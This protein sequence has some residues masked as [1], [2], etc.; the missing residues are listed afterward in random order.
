[1][2]CTKDFSLLIRLLQ[3]TVKDRNT[4]FRNRSY[5]YARLDTD[6]VYRVSKSE[7]FYVLNNSVKSKPILI[8]LVQRNS[9]EI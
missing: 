7:P 6:D 2:L 4:P 3:F 1:V 5:T 9:E 8:I